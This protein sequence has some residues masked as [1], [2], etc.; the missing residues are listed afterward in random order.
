MKYMQ[1][2]IFNIPMNYEGGKMILQQC[3]N[4]SHTQ[5]PSWRAKIGIEK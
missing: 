5:L 1:E 3:K 4:T 2:N